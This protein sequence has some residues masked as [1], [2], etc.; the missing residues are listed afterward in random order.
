MS[1]TRLFKK[2]IGWN[3][4]SDIFRK[5]VVCYK[6]IDYNSNAMQKFAFL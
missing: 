4:F 5:V 6:S 1:N 3:D 2:I